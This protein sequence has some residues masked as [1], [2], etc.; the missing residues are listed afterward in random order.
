MSFEFVCHPLS[1]VS[2]PAAFGLEGMGLRELPTDLANAMA[3]RML[4][5][6]DARGRPNGVTSG[7]GKMGGSGGG[8]M[9]MMQG[10]GSGSQG[11][12]RGASTGLGAGGFNGGLG[13][14]AI[15]GGV[16]NGVAGSPNRRQ[17]LLSRPNIG[18]RGS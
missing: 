18:G 10:G 8:G 2:G 6:M 12:S 17:A 16:G 15:A 1:V 13:G 7:G 14:R 9:M 4:T 11:G 5:A 3:Q